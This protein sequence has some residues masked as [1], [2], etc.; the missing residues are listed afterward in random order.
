MAAVVTAS[1]FPIYL[2]DSVRIS[3][4]AVV[5]QSGAPVTNP[6]SITLLIIRPDF[7]TAATENTSAI[8]N[9][10]NGNYHYDFAISTTEQ[11][12]LWQAKFT[13][14]NGAYTVNSASS[15]Q[16]NSFNA[17]IPAASSTTNAPSIN[18]S[19][20]TSAI[21]AGASIAGPP[22]SIAPQADYTVYISGGNYYATAAADLGITFTLGGYSD[23]GALLNQ[24]FSLLP[25]GGKIHFRQGQYNF[26]TN[27]IFP[28]NFSDYVLEGEGAA[29]GTFATFFRIANGATIASMLS[30]NPASTTSK[31]LVVKDIWFDDNKQALTSLLS[32][33]ASGTNAAGASVLNVASAGSLASGVII[34][35]APGTTSAERQIVSSVSGNAI[36]LEG[37]LQFAH[38]S[39]DVVNQAT[40]LFDCTQVETSQSFS[41]DRC[42]F[43]TQN[44]LNTYALN[45]TGDEDT[46]LVHCQF[47]NTSTVATRLCA[48]VPGGKIVLVGGHYFGGVDFQAQA[49]QIFGSA[50]GQ[51]QVT[52]GSGITCIGPVSTGVGPQL[53][54][55]EGV[56][57]NTVLAP[58]TC[59]QNNSG[60]VIDVEIGAGCYAFITG[61]TAKSFFSGA[62]SF[63]VTW[64]HGSIFVK[65][66]AG[67]PTAGTIFAAGD[68]S[69]TIQMIGLHVLLQQLGGTPTSQSSLVVGGSAS[70]ALAPMYPK[71][72][73]GQVG[74]MS[75]PF[76]ATI[77]SPYATATSKTIGYGGVANVPVS[78]T[79]YTVNIP[80]DLS[81]SAGTGQTITTEDCFGNII[82]NAVATLSHRFLLP[83]YSLT[84]TFTSVGS[85]TAISAGICQ[86]SENGIPAGS[87]AAPTVSVNY[88]AVQDCYITSAGTSMS[89]TVKDGTGTTGGNTI[90]SGLSALTHYFLAA[91]QMIIWTAGSGISATVTGVS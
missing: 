75:T 90:D 32:T 58:F 53:L 33:T 24:I 13:F 26:S 29:P 37:L 91:G 66:S 49:I 7:T 43:R 35:I 52:S 85:T 59:V 89:V 12:G 38:S 81:I 21:S 63:R 31:R 65:Y 88:I 47:N 45:V 83:G 57:W 87:N 80:L 28:N 61:S 86:I 8:S 70:Y 54:A 56:Y 36:T 73:F 6:S 79:K 77:S 27:A 25:S 82:D 50:L 20:S 72:D 11:T 39:N 30:L 1:N 74:V 64:S 4:L 23:I 46:I 22:Y 5:D 78:G 10:G 42:C 2:G 44:A 40:T 62:S 17:Q 69:S 51:N 60:E 71:V 3:A 19:A 9:D 84:V 48:R 18:V 16:V 76:G 34:D 68:N 14:V 15:F 41:F 67:N 55:C